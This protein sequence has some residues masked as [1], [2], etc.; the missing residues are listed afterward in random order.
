MYK[1]IIFILILIPLFINAQEFTLKKTDEEI[2]H[3]KEIKEEK[4]YL[5]FQDHFFNALQQK[6]KE[7]YNK[8]IEELEECKQ[9]FPNDAGLNF[10]FA[11]NY[12]LLK[13]YENAIYFDNEV[14]KVKPNNIYIFEHLKKIYKTQRDYDSAIEIQNKIIALKPSKKSELIHLYIGNREKNKAKE[15]FLEMKDKNEIINN[16]FYWKRI[17]F[18]QPKII[19][20]THKKTLNN[21]VD[22]SIK[23]L[24]LRFNK[25]KDFKTLKQLLIE[26]EKQA[27]YI[28][29]TN[30][31]KKGLELFPAQPFLYLMQGKGELKSTNHKNAIEVLKAGLDFIIDDDN[32]TS[33][34]YKNIAEAYK[35]L[36]NNK[37]AN[38]YL[39]KSNKLK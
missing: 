12:L 26:E 29:L 30:D 5:K 15:L 31:S 10:E 25:N 9:I 38:K 7:D 28:L 20:N 8:A 13:D 1:K 11:K 18:R 4:E 39:E 32:L 2:K 6:S 33:T 3:E 36:G 23:T 22:N 17:L 19:T 16:E 35:G 24:Q 27:K 37:E 21:N 14:L 34:F